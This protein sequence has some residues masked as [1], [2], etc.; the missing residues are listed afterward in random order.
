MENPEGFLAAFRSALDRLTRPPLAF[1]AGAVLLGLSLVVVSTHL[2]GLEPPSASRAEGTR[3]GDFL[4][5]WTGAVTLAEG[6]GD[7]LY[8]VEAQRRLQGRILGRVPTFFQPYLNPPLLAVLLSALVPLGY[9]TAFHL[10]GLGSALLLSLG[11]ALLV[12][13][14]PHIRAQ[15]F[16]TWTLFVLVVDYQPMLQTALVGQNSSTTFALLAALTLALQ[17]SWTWV[18][19]V[20]LGLLTYKPQYA[21]GVGIALL[22]AG[23]WRVVVGGGALGVA[24]W[25]LGAWWCGWR[26]PLEM[27]AFLRQAQPLEQASNEAYHFSWVRT[28]DLLLPGPADSVAAVAGVALVL[29][30]WWRF[31]DLGRRGE[32]AWMALVVCGTSLASPHLQYYDAA[33]L[34]LPACLL[35]EEVLRAGRPVTFGTRMLLATAFFGYPAWKLGPALG[36][37]PLFFMLL[38]LAWWATR[39]CVDLERRDVRTSRG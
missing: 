5:F 14:L 15:P 16:G 2:V 21:I 7:E 33:L 34:T 25:L 1:A 37:Q 30:A 17:R 11:L 10:Y 31:R 8:D 13:A 4:A 6:R 38:G 12:R 32:C 19:A 18:A 22:M 36:V 39:T 3:T 9:L 28:A 27:L 26:W 23:H 20:V 29:A 35:V 24:H